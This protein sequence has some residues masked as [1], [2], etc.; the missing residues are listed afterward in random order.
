MT[1]RGT[2]SSRSARTSRD[3]GSSRRY[4]LRYGPAF[5][6]LQSLIHRTLRAPLTH[7][8]ERF[9]TVGTWVAASALTAATVLRVTRSWMV[10]GLTF[11]AVFGHL[12]LLINEPGHPQGSLVLVIALVTLLAAWNRENAPFQ[13]HVTAAGVLTAFALLVKVN[14]GAYL[15]LGFAV[16][17]LLWSRL[18]RSRVMAA[19][20]AIVAAGVCVLPLVVTRSHVRGWALNYALIACL[21]LASTI[22]VIASI[23]Q[24]V[25]PLAVTLRYAVATGFATVLLIL[26]ALIRGTSI[27]TLLTGIVL[28][29]FELADRFQI[30][31]I[32]PTTGVLTA[33]A[34][35]ALGV[36]FALS[37]RLR[38]PPPPLAIAGTKMLM[39]AAALYWFQVGYIDKLTYITPF[40]WI[41]AVPPVDDASRGQIIGRSI[42]ALMAVVQSL[43]AYPVAGSQLAFATFLMIPAAFVCAHDVSVILERQLGG[44]RLWLRAV[45]V[46][47]VVVGLNIYGPFVNPRPWRAAYTAGYE[48]RLRGAERLRLPAAEVARYHWI[49]GTVAANCDALLTLPGLYSFNAWS[50]IPPVSRDNATAWMTLLSDE[51]Q[52]SVWRAVDHANHVCT[53]YNPALAATWLVGGAVE[54]LP[55]YRGMKARFHEVA[56]SGGYQLLMR[57]RDVPPSGAFMGLVAG[58]QKFERTRSPLPILASFAIEPATSTLRTWVRSRRTGVIAGCQSQEHEGLP[59]SRWLPMLYIGNT[60]RL[61]GQHWTADMQVQASEQPVNDGSWHHV[62]LVKEQNEQQL[63]V[64]GALVGSSRST[65]QTAG[66]SW[67]QTGTGATSF[68]PAAP[69]GWMPFNGEIEGLGVSLQAWNAREVAEDWRRT[70][71]QD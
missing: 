67:C 44:S 24:S 61:Y 65:D 22:V 16:P 58:R 3:T 38:R 32:L 6:V 47:L 18:P 70:R 35:L 25:V 71:P 50:D 11:L 10:A 66:L 55:A 4:S 20:L 42:L 51:E 2:S 30:P 64:D 54:A 21:S 49:S 29:P 57:D 7:D 19:L 8:L 31:L 17:L 45:Q 52:E 5:Y 46:S 27:S 60:G 15:A 53:I 48:L 68:W 28:R 23:R 62:A 39:A 34:G 43:Q 56:A 13:Q 12:V 1:T 26:P 41:V 9:L 36:A 33:G 14:I 63:Y 69:R 40:L 59:S 37:V